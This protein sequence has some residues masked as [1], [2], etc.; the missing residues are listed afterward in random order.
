MNTKGYVLISNIPLRNKSRECKKIEKKI[1]SSY[2]EYFC[3]EKV[4]KGINILL[5]DIAEWISLYNLEGPIINRL[6]AENPSLEPL[7]LKQKRGKWRNLK[8]TFRHRSKQMQLIFANHIAAHSKFC[9]E[10]IFLNTMPTLQ[11]E[12]NLDYSLPFIV[13]VIYKQPFKIRHWVQFKVGSQ[14]ITFL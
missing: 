7:H 8:K 4:I 3:I 5:D 1:I 14:G 10:N 13:N 9:V 12:L 2:K 11:F 6:I